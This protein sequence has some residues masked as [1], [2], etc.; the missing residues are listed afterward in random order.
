MKKLT[1]TIY[2]TDEQFE[3]NGNKDIQEAVRESKKDFGKQVE[4]GEIMG[5]DCRVEDVE[6]TEQFLKELRD[7]LSVH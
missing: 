7:G 1:F 3:K 2:A 6:V 5:F 4:S